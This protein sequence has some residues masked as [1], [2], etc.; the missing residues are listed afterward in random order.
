MNYMF[1]WMAVIAFL[2]VANTSY[3]QSTGSNYR[4]AVG[5]KGYFGG[6]DIGSVNLKHFIARDKAIE[7]G[8]LFADG[9]VALEGMYQWHAPIAGTSGL[10][11]YVGPGVWLGS[12][13][14][15]KNNSELYLAAKGVFGLDY[16][17]QGAPINLALDFNPQLRLTQNTDFDFY[18]GFAF[19]FAF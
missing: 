16:K 17:I 7:G 15:S 14:R 13:Q 19:R 18:A 10:Q 6:P 11:W 2:A 3:A 5:I 1:K 4:T 8:L 9:F 12:T